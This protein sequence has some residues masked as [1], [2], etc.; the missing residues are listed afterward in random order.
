MYIYAPD[1]TKRH[2]C[3]TCEKQPYPRSNQEH[4]RTTTTKCI[5]TEN[6]K[7]MK[8]ESNPNPNRIM[9]HPPRQATITIK[10]TTKLNI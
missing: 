5:H 9:I 8:L 7:I 4:T 3:I 1:D 6:E 2:K 10:I